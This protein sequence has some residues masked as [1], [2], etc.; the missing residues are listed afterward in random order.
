VLDWFVGSTCADNAHAERSTK[1]RNFAADSPQPDDTQRLAGNLASPECP[2]VEPAADALSERARQILQQ[3]HHGR[4][5][6][7][8]D[9]HGAAGAT[10]TRDRNGAAPQIAA[11]EIRDARR[12]LVHETQVRRSAGDSARRRERDAHDF[13]RREHCM[14]TGTLYVAVREC[15][16]ALRQIPLRSVRWPVGYQLRAEQLPGV[17]HVES[18]IDRHDARPLT[19]RHRCDQHDLQHAA[20]FFVDLAC[21]TLQQVFASLDPSAGES[22]RVF[23]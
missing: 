16:E 17:L 21:E 1:P 14:P 10:S 5:G 19:L 6:P 8:C 7:F 18:A 20:A 3:R 11:G 13:R 23:S 22:P 9:R 15:L 2:P 4:D 12:K